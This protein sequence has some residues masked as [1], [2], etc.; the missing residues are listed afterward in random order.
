MSSSVV[1]IQ[2]SWRAFREAKEGWRE[3]TEELWEAEVRLGA[4]GKKRKREEIVI[5]DTRARDVAI[6]RYWEEARQRFAEE[7]GKYQA[8]LAEHSPKLPSFH[9]LPSQ[10]ELRLLLRHSQSSV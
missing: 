1:R 3:R 6:G 2:G 5:V 8:G 4:K 10:S 9:P 7:W